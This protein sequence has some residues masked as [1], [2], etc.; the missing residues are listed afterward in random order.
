MRTRRP[1]ISHS[2][3]EFHATFVYA[4][5]PLPDFNGIWKVPN[6]S[7][8]NTSGIWTLYS[9]TALRAFC[10][11]YTVI[12]ALHTLHMF[13]LLEFDVKF[14]IEWQAWL[15]LWIMSQLI[16]YLYELM[17][18]FGSAWWMFLGRKFLSSH[19]HTI[20]K[21]KFI[22]TASWTLFFLMYGV[23]GQ[24]GS[25]FFFHNFIWLYHY[26]LC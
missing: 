12:L 6:H 7:M 11:M 9:K 26:L 24:F 8:N 22:Y 21:Q 25:L 16:I 10:L 5:V 20:P 13:N 4:T 19:T 1:H 15:T 14:L 2:L 3:Y 23:S 17:I 18:V